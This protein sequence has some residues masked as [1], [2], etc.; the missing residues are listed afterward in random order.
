MFFSFFSLCVRLTELGD[1]GAWSAMNY[2][3][4]FDKFW[5]FDDNVERINA[6]DVN[7]DEFIERYE[8]HNKPV[9]IE[10]LQVQ[11]TCFNHV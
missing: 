2:A 10:E 3:S 5:K 4:C 8:K 6:R 1:K 11:N 9:V 7:C